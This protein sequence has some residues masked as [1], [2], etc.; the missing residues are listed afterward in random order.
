MCEVVFIICGGCPPEYR[1]DAAGGPP[2]LPLLGA[3]K[4]YKSFPNATSGFSGFCLREGSLT[5]PKADSLLLFVLL[6]S[7]VDL[8]IE[9]L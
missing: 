3:S 9:S 5:P 4:R 6:P 7:A 8:L 2:S 1:R